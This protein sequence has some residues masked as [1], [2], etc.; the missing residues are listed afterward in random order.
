MR[1]LIIIWSF[2][3]FVYLFISPCYAQTNQSAISKKYTAA[4]LKEDTKILKDVTIA[5]HPAIGIYQ[6]KNYYTNL[7][8]IFI[9]K[10]ND[11]LTEKEFRIKLKLLMENLHCGHT[12]VINSKKY[13]REINKN[14]LNF[15]TLLFLP[16]QNKLY[17]IGDLNKKK[18]TSLLKIGTEIIRINGIAVDSIINYSKRFI[19]SDGYNQTSKNHFI[20]LSFNNFLVGL[21][22]RPDTFNIDYLA[23]TKIKNL[24]YSAF[25]TKSLPLLQ[26]QKKEDSLFTKY[27]RAQ[28]KYRFLDLQNKTMLLKISAFSP[29]QSAKAYRKIF[30]KLQKYQTDNLVIDLRNNGG[31]SIE[32]AYR[33]LSYLIDTSENQTLRTNI[34]KYPYK[35]YTRG[36]VLFKLTRFVFGILSKKETKFETD[37]YTFTIKPRKKNH[38]N[39]K[40]LVLI[41]GGSFSAS[42][43]VAAYL[44]NNN[45]AEF[46]GEETGG[47]I[48]GCNAGVMPYYKLPNTNVRVRMPAFRVINDVCPKIT[49][50]GLLPDYKTKYSLTDYIQQIDV[51]LIKVKEILKLD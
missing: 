41:N 42:I 34:K 7:F 10:L 47:T 38:F 19:S 36:N 35:K 16:I 40:I 6:S 28:I 44:K 26:L 32:N 24:K 17:V 12:D 20:Q 39:K 18:D 15:S 37:N 22:G 4:E 51:D 5:M 13:Y 27:K 33:L 31:G 11:S 1:F 14:K 3:F 48:E 43:L 23:G 45:R 29:V 8:D 21:F 30:K 9:S 49:A 25:K 46:I 50:H 2:I